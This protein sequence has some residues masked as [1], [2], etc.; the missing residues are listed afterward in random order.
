M[1]QTPKNP[2]STWRA[3]G[4][5]RVPRQSRRRRT[6]V[7]VRDGRAADCSL[8]ATAA[9]LG[10]GFVMQSNC[11]PGAA[12]QNC[13]W[14]N[15]LPIRRARV[16][17]RYLPLFRKHAGVLGSCDEVEVLREKRQIHVYRVIHCDGAIAGALGH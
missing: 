4:L 8:M 1:R 16:P 14:R 11:Q 9:L 2:S 6:T 13:K 10:S 12:Y 3:I 17:A 15:L 7:V 5:R